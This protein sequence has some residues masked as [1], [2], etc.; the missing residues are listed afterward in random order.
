VWT[1]A[2]EATQTVTVAP[3]KGPGAK[4]MSRPLVP[5]TRPPGRPP[6]H[7]ARALARAIEG[8]KLDR[9]S[10]PAKQR[11]LAANL[12]AEDAGGS[13][14]LNNREVALIWS[15]ASVWVL[16]NLRLDALLAGDGK[17]DHG[18]QKWMVALLNSFR[19]NLE[20]L[21]LKPERVED[22]IPTLEQYLAAKSGSAN[23]APGSASDSQGDDRAEVQVTL[24]GADP[25]AGEGGA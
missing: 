18:S 10:R 20:V 22:R 14:Y 1:S 19:R 13:P 9:R 15:T 12:L 8:N 11:Q 7:G 16:L 5:M 25:A 23:G 21:G 17:E 6:K 24:Q 4:P 2:G 3:E